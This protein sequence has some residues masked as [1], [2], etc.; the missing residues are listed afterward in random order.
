MNR[1]HPCCARLTYN[2]DDKVTR[3]TR[4][5]EQTRFKYDAGQQRYERYDVKVEGG[6]TT[7]LTTQYVAGYEKVTRTKKRQDIYGH[8]TYCKANV[9]FLF[10]NVC[11]YSSI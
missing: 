4:G 1:S 10:D 6:V 2:S 11:L 5:N 8:L 7:Y 9:H 3:I